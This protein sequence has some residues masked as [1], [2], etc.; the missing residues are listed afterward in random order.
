MLKRVNAVDPF[1]SNPNGTNLYFCDIHNGLVHEHLVTSE[2]CPYCENIDMMREYAS[3]HP[4]V[5]N[6]ATAA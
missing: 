3:W 6:K 1:Y 2:G 4:S 5:K